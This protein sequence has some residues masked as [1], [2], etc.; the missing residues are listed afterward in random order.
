MNPSDGSL[1]DKQL[2]EPSTESFEN[3]LCIHCLKPNI[4]LIKFCRHCR[5]PVHPL[6]AWCPY[7]KVYATGFIWRAA[8]NKPRKMIVLIGI[9][10]YFLPTF[11][12]NILM[13]RELLRGPYFEYAH[14]L[15]IVITLTPMIAY[16]LVTLLMMIKTTSNYLNNRRK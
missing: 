4:P 6:A 8:A 3:E 7:E 14:R 11:L 5:A 12:F 2:E 16:T 10:L 13:L 9:Y 15:N 1:S